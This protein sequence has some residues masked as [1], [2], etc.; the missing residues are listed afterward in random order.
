MKRLFIMLLLLFTMAACGD[1]LFDS[2]A[3]SNEKT[4]RADA[5]EF[6]LND[7]DY[8]FIL[9]K[10]ENSN[11]MNNYYEHLNLREKY[12]LQS[13]WMG[14][15]GFSLLA[16]LD[17]LFDENAKFTDILM[18]SLSGGNNLTEESIGKRP[19]GGQPGYGKRGYYLKVINMASSQFK[20]ND[21]DFMSGLAVTMDV[22]M[23]VAQVALSV[24]G[25]DAVSFN[26]DDENYLNKIFKSKS[27]EEIK[28]SI[29]GELVAELN[30]TKGQLQTA[31]DT[32]PEDGNKEVRDK[33]QNYMNDMTNEN[34]DV[35]DQSLFIFI[36]KNYRQ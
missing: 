10:L 14:K 31:I 21:I 26:A 33:M 27:E 12:L 1:N 3:D 19:N 8:D 13:A 15:S 7:K 6:A 30:S 23:G 2:M 17:A 20:N 28:D 34:G 16:N 35:T 4:P 11:P 29:S 5:M 18:K 24:S 22:L 9:R 32:F 25:L 36:D